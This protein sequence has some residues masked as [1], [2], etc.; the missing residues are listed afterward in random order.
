MKKDEKRVVKSKISKRDVARRVLAG[1]LVAMT[2]LA[3]MSTMIYYIVIN[4]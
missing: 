2:L 3:A 4:V 1:A